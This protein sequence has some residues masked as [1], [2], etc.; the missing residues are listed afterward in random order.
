M[1]SIITSCIYNSNF[2]VLV[3]VKFN[4]NMINNFNV[5]PTNSRNLPMRYSNYICLLSVL[6]TG[7]DV[8]AFWKIG[9]CNITDVQSIMDGCHCDF[10]IPEYSVLYGTGIH[11]H[12]C[13]KVMGFFFAVAKYGVYFLG[14]DLKFCVWHKEVFCI[15]NGKY[16]K[17]MIYRHAWVNIQIW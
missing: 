3:F 12:S 2:C 10:T 11:V 13:S 16:I 6:N 8:I 7:F 5:V 17:C 15:H 4:Q 14:T 9:L 1:V